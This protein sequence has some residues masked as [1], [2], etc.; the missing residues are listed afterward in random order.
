MKRLGRYDYYAKHGLIEFGPCSNYESPTMPTGPYDAAFLPDISQLFIAMG[1]DGLLVR[2]P[3]GNWDWI[4]VEQYRLEGVA[5]IDLSIADLWPQFLM[6]VAAAVL[7]FVLI[8]QYLGRSCEA[9]VATTFAWLIWVVSMTKIHL[10][11]FATDSSA[12]DSASQM[13]AWMLLGFLPLILGGLAFTISYLK[14]INLSQVRR[15]LII[16][17]ASSFLASFVPFLRWFGVGSYDNYLASTHQAIF[18]VIATQISGL[19]FM[20]V[21]YSRKFASKGT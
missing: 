6:S 4:A 10:T 9:I 15:P 16:I 11:P 3:N 20:R 5:Q 2:Q 14:S 19:V 8:G 18:L 17:T 13:T 21:W 1:L 12:F 7:T